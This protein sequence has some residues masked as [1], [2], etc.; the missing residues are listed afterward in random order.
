MTG[1]GITVY[2]V[3]LYKEVR[4][5]ERDIAEMKKQILS[6]QAQSN[7]ITAINNTKTEECSISTA[8]LTCVAPAKQ[9]ISVQKPTTNATPVEYVSDDDAD[10]V[11]SNEIKDI[12]TNIH[13]DGEEPDDAETDNVVH[14]SA[15]FQFITDNDDVEEKDLTSLN[16]TE[17]QS[18]KYDDIR[19]FLRKKGFSNK[20]TKQDYIQKILEMG[21]KDNENTH[22]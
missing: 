20:G 17:L 4:G 15:T 21:R 18:M 13:D 2:M 11:T 10:S 19:N 5:F 6:I 9:S 14:R 22:K 3:F 8:G 1:V 7:H 12:L 16:E